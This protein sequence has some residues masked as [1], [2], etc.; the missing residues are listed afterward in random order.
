MTCLPRA[1][2]NEVESQNMPGN[3]QEINALE[4]ETGLGQQS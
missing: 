4:R 3:E 2:L 1:R